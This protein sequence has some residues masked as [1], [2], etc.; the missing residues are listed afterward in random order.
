MVSSFAVSTN[1]AKCFKSATKAIVEI[2]HTPEQIY[3]QHMG[4]ED[5]M[6][7]LMALY[8]KYQSNKCLYMRIFSYFK[9]SYCKMP[10]FFREKWKR[11]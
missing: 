11:C 4:D 8:L 9:C 2:D 3:N 7:S 10:G 6:V 1:K 5:L